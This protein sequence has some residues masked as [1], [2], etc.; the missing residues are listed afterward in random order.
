MAK[1]GPKPLPTHLKMVKGIV[2]KDRINLHEPKPKNKQPR[3]P[4][5]LS[6]DAKKIWKRTIHQL[7]LMGILYESDIDIIIAYCNAVVNYQKATLIVDQSGVLIKGRRDSVVTNPAVRV[8]RDAATL[9][10]MLASELG[11]TPS[12]RS[13]LSSENNDSDNILD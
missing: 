8:Q 9:I 11:L 3:C 10:R 4:E 6:E 13:R 1:P 2:R 12:S 7:K 5:W